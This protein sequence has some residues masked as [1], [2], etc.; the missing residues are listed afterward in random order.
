MNAC[1]LVVGVY[2]A[3]KV[4]SY[5]GVCCAFVI[6]TVSFFFAMVIPFRSFLKLFFG[7]RFFRL[8]QI[9]GA[10]DVSILLVR[11]QLLPEGKQERQG[12]PHQNGDADE[13]G[14]A[15]VDLIVLHSASLLQGS[16]I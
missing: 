6:A 15:V 14:Q 8:A 3:Y 11:Q 7:G 12:Q 2:L 9:H 16:S 5:T 10:E 1:C 4:A 13:L